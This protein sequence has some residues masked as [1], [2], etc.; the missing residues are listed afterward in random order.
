MCAHARYTKLRTAAPEDCRNLSGG[1]RL[2]NGTTQ[3]S[4]R[5]TSGLT[6]DPSC[7]RVRP[8]LLIGVETIQ[9]PHCGRCMVSNR[10]CKLENAREWQGSQVSRTVLLRGG[11]QQGGAILHAARSDAA[12]Y[13]CAVCGGSRG[14]AGE[15]L[16]PRQPP[17][18]PHAHALPSPSSPCAFRRLHRGNPPR[19]TG[20]LPAAGRCEP[21]QCARRPFLS[22]RKAW[23]Q[24]AL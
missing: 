16:A 2:Q 18:H 21:A 15:R 12:L 1:A 5:K 8:S 22:R 20:A 17:L 10:A 11:C 14:I 24:W 19:A 13:G 9:R 3:T 23:Q 6:C 7:A 4:P